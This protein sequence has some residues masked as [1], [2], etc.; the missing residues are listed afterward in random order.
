MVSHYVDIGQYYVTVPHARH[1]PW[2]V[3]LIQ[4]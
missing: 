1:P 2:A 3:S 4:T